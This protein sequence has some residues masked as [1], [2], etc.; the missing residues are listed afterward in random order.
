MLSSAEGQTRPTFVAGLSSIWVASNMGK[1]EK[2]VGCQR[3]WPYAEPPSSICLSPLLRPRESNLSKLCYQ[4]LRYRWIQVY[5]NIRGYRN[6]KEHIKSHSSFWKCK[7]NLES[8]N[9]LFLKYLCN[10][11]FCDWETEYSERWILHALTPIGK[12]C[13]Q[14]GVQTRGGQW[15]LINRQSFSHQACKEPFW[16]K[17]WT[18]CFF[19]NSGNFTQ[20]K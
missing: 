10:K 4:K 12:S 20:T 17:Q 16:S 7:T 5:L 2:A 19:G 15:C 3:A 1:A 18:V 14:T 8:R 13:H 6:I 11:M 9:Y